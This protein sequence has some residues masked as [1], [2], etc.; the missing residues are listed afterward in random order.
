MLA[1]AMAL[2]CESVVV[3]VVEEGMGREDTGMVGSLGMAIQG[4]EEGI[5]GT[6]MVV[7]VAVVVVED[8]V[9]LVV[10]AWDQ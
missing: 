1:S 8:E 6:M 5:Q 3:V 9:L 2:A 10:L 4:T 7:V